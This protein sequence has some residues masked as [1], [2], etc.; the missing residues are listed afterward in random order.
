MSSL[1]LPP[2]PPQLPLLSPFYHWLSHI[3]LPSLLILFYFHLNSNLLVCLYTPFVIPLS[4]LVYAHYHTLYNHPHYLIN[5]LCLHLH[6]Y[7][8]SPYLK[9]I[10][11]QLQALIPLQLF[12][13]R[14]GE[15]FLSVLMQSFSLFLSMVGDM[16]C[17]LY[18]RAASMSS[19]LFG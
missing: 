4:L 3:F 14:G 2:P 8:L 9:L 19:T 6:C 7:S 10:P 11:N 12:R 18:M 17:M 1:P 5:L 15:R 16:I 13:F